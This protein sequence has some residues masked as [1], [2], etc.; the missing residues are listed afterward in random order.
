MIR[1]ALPLC[2][3]VILVYAGLQG[4]SSLQ[5]EAN[6]HLVKGT[7]ADLVAA[8]GLFGQLLVGDAASANLWSELAD[9]MVMT[10]RVGEARYCFSRAIE[11]AP[12]VPQILLNVADFHIDVG[13]RQASLPYFGKILASTNAPQ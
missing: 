10:A 3:G 8:R 12:R 4:G 11:L 13:E 6:L 7:D 5:E 2:S 9:T 1:L